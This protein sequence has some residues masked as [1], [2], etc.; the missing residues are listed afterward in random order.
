M[1][2]LTQ[3]KISS[4]TT[5]TDQ[6]ETAVSWRHPSVLAVIL[7]LVLIAGGV[8]FWLKAAQI[9][10]P[11]SADVGFAR[12][13]SEHHRQAVEMSALLYDRTE[14]ETMRILAYDI[15]T[16][17]QAQIGIMSGWLDAWGYRWSSIGPKMEWMGMSVEG[18]MPGMA[19]RAELNQLTA[20]QGTEADAIFM[21]LMI[22]HHRAGVVMAEAAAAQAKTEIVRNLAQGMAE[23]QQ[24]EIEY[25][26]QLLQEKGYEPV[27][28]ESPMEMDHQ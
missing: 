23:A 6:S 14:D 12:D 27:P 22:P 13:M 11:D 24:T 3:E 18:L 1:T 17:Q 15:L 28:D 19:T 4:S 7:L 8:G 9:P 5:H 26:Q 10:D 25:M 2:E 21:Q 20:A 16:T